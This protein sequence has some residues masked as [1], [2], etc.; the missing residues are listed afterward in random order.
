LA[1]LRSQAQ[2]PKK[3]RALRASDANR[4]ER[5]TGDGSPVQGA[6]P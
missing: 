4:G 3:K 5:E 6:V 1:E 2:P